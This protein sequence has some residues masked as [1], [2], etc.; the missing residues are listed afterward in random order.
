MLLLILNILS[1]S[2]LLS[3]TVDRAFPWTTTAISASAASAA[4][5]PSRR[6]PGLTETGGRRKQYYSR[7]GVACLLWR[8]FWLSVRA[9][10][11]G[12]GGGGVQ[13]I[14]RACDGDGSHVSPSGGQLM[15]SSY[16]LVR[17]HFILETRSERGCVHLDPG[18][19]LLNLPL[20]YPWAVKLP[21]PFPS[22][23]G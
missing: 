14:A 6:L 13:C 17:L 1:A 16:P 5:P 11:E 4:G 21:P 22:Y 9:F 20:P 2:P 8:L 10:Q 23:R 19:I 12:R 3:S 18:R 15:A 7:R